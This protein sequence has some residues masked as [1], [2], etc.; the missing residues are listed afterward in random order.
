MDSP[1]DQLLALLKERWGPKTLADLRDE[2]VLEDN[3]TVFESLRVDNGPRL[4]LVVCVTNGEQIE[5]IERAI[6]LG[7]DKPPANWDTSTLQEMVVTTIKAGG[8][9]Y[10]DLHDAYGKRIAVTLCATGPDSMKIVEA[11]FKLP[12]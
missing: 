3:G 10:E 5:I 7:E 9:T 6:S 11:L 4:L 2:A 12:A 1:A 8:L